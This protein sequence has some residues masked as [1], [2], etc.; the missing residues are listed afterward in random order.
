MRLKN[1]YSVRTVRCA[2][3]PTSNSVGRSHR[4]LSIIIG[5]GSSALH[6]QASKVFPRKPPTKRAQIGWLCLCG[7]QSRG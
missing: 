3:N 5:L 6:P 7:G 1:K 4:R 2:R